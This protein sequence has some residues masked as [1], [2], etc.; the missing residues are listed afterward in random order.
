MIG[1]HTL[2]YMKLK[3]ALYR[4]AILEMWRRDLRPEVVALTIAKLSPCSVLTSLNT[5]VESGLFFCLAFSSSFSDNSLRSSLSCS[6]QAFS[7]SWNESLRSSSLFCNCSNLVRSRLF[8]YSSF[9]TSN[10][11]RCN[12]FSFSVSNFVFNCSFWSASNIPVP[13][14]IRKVRRSPALFQPHNQQWL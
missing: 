8:F 10:S 7:A 2:V 9:T 5:S 4:E 1:R 3:N 11:I 12:S 14:L 13:L 6:C